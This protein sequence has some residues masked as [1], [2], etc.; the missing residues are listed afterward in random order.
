M[1]L[2]L[3]GPPGAGKGTQAQKLVEKYSMTHLSS[4][5]IFRAEKASGSEL[6]KKL[7]D[8]IDRGDLVPDDIVVDIMASAITKID[9]SL[10]LDGF[11]RTVA[12]A[13][14]LDKTLAGI[15]SKLDAVVVI[16]VDDDAIIERITGRRSCPSTGKV[17]HIRFMP[18][19]VDGVDD[20]T[21]E[22]LVQRDDDCEAVVRDRL[23][24]YHTQTAPVIDYYKQA[25]TAKVITVDGMGTPGEVSVRMAEA[26]KQLE[27]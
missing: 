4:G 21:G 25:D 1:R 26:V 17:Y 23:S 7:A 18:P 8:I 19:K 11:P 22:P 12:Q 14:A 6:G 3:I 24:T 5:D 27:S 20:E 16:T 13:K 2:V 9:G 10:L 15:G